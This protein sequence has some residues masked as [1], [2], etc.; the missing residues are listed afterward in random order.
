MRANDN[1][2]DDDDICAPSKERGTIVHFC[3]SAGVGA[4]DLLY[5]Y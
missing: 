4:L 3:D 2:D 5:I 1:D